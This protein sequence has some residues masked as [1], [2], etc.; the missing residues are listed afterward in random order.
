MKSEKRR[1][2]AVQQA[3]EVKQLW[4]QGPESQESGGVMTTEEE[5]LCCKEWEL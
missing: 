3:E 4:L 5:C 2:E 1:E